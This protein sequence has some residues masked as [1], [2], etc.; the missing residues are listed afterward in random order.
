MKNCICLYH[1]ASIPIQL[2]NPSDIS[3]DS[4]YPLE[5]ITIAMHQFSDFPKP[6]TVVRIKTWKPVKLDETFSFTATKPR[7]NDFIARQK[8]QL[9][10]ISVFPNP[11][12][13]SQALERDKYQRFVPVYKPSEYSRQSESNTI[14]RV[15]SWIAF[16]IKTPLPNMWT[17]IC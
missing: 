13:G 10:R 16:E 5:K 15:F 9:D 1:R 14:A 8:S 6:G 11:Y 3:A 4:S 7:I 12:F 17:G 2:Q